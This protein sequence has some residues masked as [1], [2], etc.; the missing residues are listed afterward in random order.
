MQELLVSLINLLYVCLPK[1]SKYN[2]EMQEVLTGSGGF[3]SYRFSFS[4]HPMTVPCRMFGLMNIL[5]SKV[6][7]PL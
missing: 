1:R 4:Y 6:E 7:A 2:M 3:V 5:N